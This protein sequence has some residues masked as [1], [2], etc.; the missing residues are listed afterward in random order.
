M[1]LFKKPSELHP[2]FAISALLYGSPGVSKT[3]TACSAPNA[4]LFDY[5]GGVTRIHGAHQVPTLQVTSWEQ[6]QDA[7][8]EIK[9]DPAIQ[10]IVVDTVGKMLNFMDEYIKRTNPKMKKYD[11]SLSLQGYGIR[12]QMFV[13]FI[14][15]ATMMGKN[16]IF[17]AHD[18][19]DKRGDDTVVRPE[20]GGSSAADLMKELD[21]VGYMEMIG[22][23]RTIAFDP[24]EKY[25]AKNTCGM[26]GKIT[27]PLLIDDKGNILAENNFM[28]QV[29][30]AYQKRQQDNLK[31]TAQYESL[32]KEIEEKIRVLENAKDCND[33][34]KWM[35]ELNHI[36][37]SK[38]RASQ[39]FGAKVKT[40]DVSYDKSS[41]KYS[42]NDK[43]LD[44]TK[45]A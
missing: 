28:C 24:C 39:L 2:K 11:G 1:S 12:K 14:K 4:V 29:V 3:T 31:Q 25:Y 7:L 42:D 5:D 23:Q 43:I 18:K 17:V 45:P 30:A 21:L 10:S 26:P 6:T 32:C 36:F 38:A 22:N 9:N 8:E 34:V 44:N 40:L 16:V 27:I 20:I 13:N 41:K 33:F 19:E 35:G 37:N 15:Q